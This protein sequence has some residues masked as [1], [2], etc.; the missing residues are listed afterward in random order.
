MLAWLWGLLTVGAAVALS[1]GGM[2]LVRRSVAV[3]V[4]QSHREVAGFIYAVVGVIYAV[5]LAL[6]VVA[7]W[8]RYSEAETNV[9][10]EA[11]ELGDLFRNAQAFPPEVRERLRE[12]IREYAQVVIEEEWPMMAERGVSP[13][14]W[15]A[16]NR[17]WLAYLEVEPRTVSE[18]SWYSES[19]D[20]LNGLG[21]YRR[22]RLLSS[23]SGLPESMW[24]VLLLGAA[25]TIA[26][27]YLFDTDR[28]VSHA[29]MVGALSGTIA[30]ILF[31]IAALEYPFS[32]AARVAPEAFE[33]LLIIFERWR[34]PE[35]Q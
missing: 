16:F 6:M 21:D 12:P 10:R 1:V 8:E 14:A 32:G 13:R 24:V 4:L 26:F 22:V 29:L 25:I 2:L 33:Q 3:E 17:L 35:L 31:L 34:Q 5:L 18:S 19:L 27:S 9:E 23:R 11:N 7:V 20:R 30:L 15:D 28:V